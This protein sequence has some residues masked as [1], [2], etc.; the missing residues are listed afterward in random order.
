MKRSTRKILQ[1]YGLTILAAVLTALFIRVFVI[2]AYRIPSYLMNPT[3]LSG[4]TIF[5]AKWPFSLGKYTP[6]RGDV[7][8]FSSPG[9]GKKSNVDSIK[10]VIGL[11]GDT[12][13]I[14]KGHAVLNGRSL[15]GKREYPDNFASEIQPGGVS[16]QI[17]VFPSVMEDSQPETIPEGFALVVGDM[18]TRTDSKR[19]K[20]LELIPLSSFKGIALWTWLSI[21]PHSNSDRGS[22]WLPHIR[23]ERM[24][25]RIE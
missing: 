5:V 1:D 24:F 3:L 14:E 8:I 10:R 15:L 20:N 12:V 17:C 23:W 2:E 18:R 19:K 11:P 21:D 4:D 13:S 16:Y 9:D 22:G 7:V 25:R 6:K